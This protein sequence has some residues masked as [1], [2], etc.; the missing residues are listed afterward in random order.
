MKHILLFISVLFF[1]GCYTER[2]AEKQVLKAQIYHPDMVARKTSEWYPCGW[3]IA[4]MDSSEMV[5]WMA[6]IDSINT[7]IKYDTTFLIKD[8][9]IIVN[10][11]CGNLNEKLSSANNFIYQLQKELNLPA[12]VIYRNIKIF[13]SAKI[14]YLNSII[15]SKSDDKDL[16]QKKYENLLKITIWLIVALAIS[17]FFNFRKL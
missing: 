4:K 14:S 17:L 12:P 16:Y 1:F 8:K 3:L 11:D 15:K 13:D 7:I 6:R 9:K 2:K 10:K 5:D